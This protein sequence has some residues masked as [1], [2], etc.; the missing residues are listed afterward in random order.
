MGWIDRQI[1]E[2]NSLPLVKFPE[3]IQTDTGRYHV[4]PYG[5]V[6]GVT[7]I[8]W[9]TKVYKFKVDPRYL[10]RG[11]ILHQD[12]E[13]HFGCFI[14]DRE[15]PL[16]SQLEA[17]VGEITPLMIEYPL[18][19]LTGVAGSPDCLGKHSKHGIVLADW[20]SST[21]NKS[22]NSCHDYLIQLAAYDHL[23]QE[24]MG[25]AC[26]RAVVALARESHDEA[27]YHW[28]EREELDSLYLEFLQRLE[29]YRN[30]H[31]VSF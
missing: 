21:K 29:Q 1:A 18:S 25:I 5:N 30:L 15:S 23:I 11:N 4:T 26:D 6:P 9:E 7:T 14:E 17:F 3:H 20:K 19:S 8:L 16:W 13:N 31:T 28:V 12:I 22:R 24:N 10:D 27:R 2:G